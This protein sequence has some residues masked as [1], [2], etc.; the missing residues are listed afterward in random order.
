MTPKTDKT[1]TRRTFIEG[2]GSVVVG[3]SLAGGL[4]GEALAKVG[5]ADRVAAAGLWP[6]PALDQVDSFL[7]ILSDNTLVAKFGKGTA[8][9]GTSTGILMMYADEL[10]VPLS[11]IRM[12]IGD[13]YL[14]P[15]Q[16]GASASNG[17][18]TEWVTVRQAAATARQA[19]LSMASAKLGVPVAN[20][21]VKDG[22]IS[23]TGT[24]QTV[25]Y[26]ELMG[27]RKFNLMISPTAPQKSP[28]Q[29]K[30][31]GTPQQIVEIPSIVSGAYSYA[32]DVRLPGMLHAQSVRPPVAGARLVSVD[33]PH[34]LPGVVKVVAKGNYLAVVAKSQWEAIRAAHALKVTWK[35][36]AT[37][38]LP[39][40]Y[41]ELFDYL[42]NGPRATQSVTSRGDA[43]AAIANA[44]KVVQATYKIDFQSHATVGPFCSVADYKDGTCVI[45]FGGQKPYDQQIAAADVLKKLI[46]PNIKQDNIRVRYVA[47]AS[48]FG[49]SE[50][51]DVS[52]EAVYLSALVGAPVR[53]QWSRAESTGWDPKGPPGLVT[54]QA[55]LDSAGKVVGFNWTW[56]SLLKQPTSAVELGDT[57]MGQLMGYAPSGWQDFFHNYMGYG[58]PNVLST[59]YNVPWTQ[60]I[61]TGLRH[62]HLRS[63]GGQNLTFAAEQFEDEIAAAV[64]MDPV[65]Y[66]LT[67]L[68][69]PRKIRAVQTVAKASG[70]Q[71]RPSPNPASSSNATEVSGRGIALCARASN[72][73]SAAVA[74]VKVNRKTGKVTVTKITSANDHGFVV[75]PP[76][77]TNT[78]K[79]AV[80]H[81]M[82]RGLFETVS[83]ASQKVTSVDWE[84]YRITGIEDAPKI[85]VVLIAPDGITPNGTF[86]GPTGASEPAQDATA[87]AIANAI[88]DATGVRVRRMPMTP[89]VVLEA[90][91]AAGK[92]K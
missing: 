82:S 13:T 80:T 59:A 24:P 75:N 88:F 4:A 43:R 86:A 57:L 2:G 51:D 3:L 52:A 55:G 74:V 87:A 10:D 1:F 60:G 67:Y 61:G 22:V 54:V 30:V 35:P 83:F 34:N 12:I 23:G 85:N 46:D 8:A 90:L 69:D 31:L 79:A 68:S 76:A 6:R 25:T 78:I 26:A 19:L 72:G 38:V 71:A 53:V 40:S 41:D 39:N 7:E 64:G 65:S 33:G 21:T 89:T 27:G 32:A 42:A 73:N 36:P 56:S 17:T 84:G 81:G 49:R 20:L 45:Y 50:A 15:D 91:K 9:Q 44:A 70:W 77:L 47:G 28:A 92:A 14:T 37:A 58:Y 48:S 29:F 5:A 16:R 11:K 63:P 18:E 62:S 66:R